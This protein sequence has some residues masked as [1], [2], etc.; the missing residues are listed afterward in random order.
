MEGAVSQSCHH[1][2]SH[3]PAARSS[4]RK[5]RPAPRPRTSLRPWHSRKYAQFSRLWF[6]AC[7]AAFTEAMLANPTE[8]PRPLGWQHGLWRHE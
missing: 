3:R 8:R 5:V 4:A 6:D 2:V 1:E 7:D